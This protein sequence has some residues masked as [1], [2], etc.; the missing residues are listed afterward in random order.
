MRWT[1]ISTFLQSLCIFHLPEKNPRFENVHQVLDTYR[2]LDGVS[3]Y[4]DLP[5]TSVL[6]PRLFPT[7]Y[8]LFS[9]KKTPSITIDGTTYTEETTLLT[10]PVILPV[11]SLYNSEVVIQ[12]KNGLRIRAY[13]LNLAARIQLRFKLMTKVPVPMLNLI[14]YCGSIRFT[15]KRNEIVN[16]NY[17]DDE[18]L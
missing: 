6:I 3:F 15:Q 10:S 4:I 16:K 17:E 11:T 14:I 8:D 1:D 9:F 5:E 18:H 13:V 12:M 2:C 7:F